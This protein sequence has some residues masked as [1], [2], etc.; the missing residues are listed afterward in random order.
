MNIVAITSK[1]HLDEVLR[2]NARAFVLIYKKGSEASDCAFTSIEQV[3]LEDE[4]LAVFSVDVLQVR[5]VH[6][7]Y[8]VTSAPALLEFV[9][10]QFKNVIKGCNGPDYF[11]SY[12]QNALYV[13]KSNGE[14]PSKSVTVY[15]T[16]SCSWCTTLKNHLRKNGIHYH[17][18]DVASDYQAAEEM[19]RKSGQR[20]VPQTDIDGEMIVGFDKARINTLLGINNL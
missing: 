6:T 3:V 9:D 18:I 7:A 8:G 2:S 1:N 4:K 11:S 15:T 13:A 14:G 17:E 19:T 16:P 5:D 20:G 10:G 12:F